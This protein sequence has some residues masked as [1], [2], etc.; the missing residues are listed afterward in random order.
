VEGACLGV[1]AVIED[2]DSERRALGR[3]LTVGGFEPALFESAETFIALEQDRRWRCL[4]IDV[5]LGGISG[6]DLQ[7]RLRSRGSGVP[8]IFMT[9]HRSDLVRERA[10]AA[11]CAAFLWK[12]VCADR[13]L[14]A[15]RTIPA[16]PQ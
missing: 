14:T 2:D 3:L 5:Q 1:V 15:I 8:I 10:E 16:E 6:L 11:G 4:I 9:A 13:L 7:R 12:P